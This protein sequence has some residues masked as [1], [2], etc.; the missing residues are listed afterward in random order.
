MK[1]TIGEIRGL[2]E[3]L[4]VMLSAKHARN[5]SWT[6]V[7]NLAKAEAEAEHTV[8]HLSCRETAD[9]LYAAAEG[10]LALPLHGSLARSLYFMVLLHRRELRAQ[11]ERA[12]AWGIDVTHLTPHLSAIT[13]RPEFFDLYL[14]MAIEFE[15]PIPGEE[16]LD[17][18]AATEASESNGGS[19]QW[20]WK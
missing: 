19:G 14:E 8:S 20:R 7:Q 17:P 13:L 9:G 5:L 3:A 6:I 18:P 4:G 2:E 11:V 15:L 12:L 10:G 1:K 16:F